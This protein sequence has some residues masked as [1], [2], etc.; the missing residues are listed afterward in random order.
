MDNIKTM[1][2][3]K[4]FICLVFLQTSF[5]IAQQ[6]LSVTYSIKVN[7]ENISDKR[8]IKIKQALEK[9]EFKLIANK[10]ENIYASEKKMT[11]D[12]TMAD[13]LAKIIS[14]YD[15]SYYSNNEK[16]LKVTNMQS[17]TFIVSSKK[18]KIKWKV[19]KESKKIG[20]F[21]CFKATTITSVNS[22]GEEKHNQIIAW[23]CPELNFNAGPLGYNGLPGVILELQIGKIIY[24]ANE[25]IIE[26][27]KLTKIIKPTKGE[28][29]TQKEFDDLML[30]L[31]EN[32]NQF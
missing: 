31:K 19:F 6:Q 28:I 15:D 14:N 18:N 23:Y 11:K 20:N 30:K 25:V 10:L 4:Y 5:S 1:I 16:N 26:S 17:K 2:K 22:Q 13:K 8:F 7:N 9:Q 27:E 32:R 12:N 29:M 21:L 24:Y 3:L